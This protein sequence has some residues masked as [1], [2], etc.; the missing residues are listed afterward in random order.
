M[1]WD[2]ETQAR[3]LDEGLPPPD[4]HEEHEDGD[5]D[6]YTPEAI[7]NR[8]E[9]KS[10]LTVYTPGHTY[11]SITYL[12]PRTRV[13]CSGFTLPVEDTRSSS[14]NVAGSSAGPSLDYRDYVTTNMG[15]WERQ[16]ESARTLVHTY[17]SSFDVVLPSKGAPV[18]LK[19][20]GEHERS[21]MLLD[22]I[23]E[24]FGIGKSLFAN[25][26]HIRMRPDSNDFKI[27]E[28]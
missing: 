18:R 10:I 4:E 9:G 20:Y 15:D 27:V 12:F 8:E 24:F 23:D 6:L 22:M 11:G 1:E 25:G 5:K 7:R 17:S 14:N 21:S 19:E 16:M 2:D 26:N 3:V 13:C 28:S